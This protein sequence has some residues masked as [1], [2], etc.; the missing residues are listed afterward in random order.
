MKGYAFDDVNHNNNHISMMRIY[1][2]IMKY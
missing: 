1:R 2:R